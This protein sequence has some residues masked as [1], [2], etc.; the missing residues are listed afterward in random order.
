LFGA[1]GA[2]HTTTDDLKLN[3]DDDE[4][5]ADERHTSGEEGETELLNDFASVHFTGKHNRQLTLYLTHLHLPGLTSVDQMHLLAVADT[6]AHFNADVID[7]MSLANDRIRQEQFGG[8]GASEID[9]TT[10]ARAAVDDCGL[11]FLIA[12]KQHEYLLRCLPI[13]QRAQLKAAGLATHHVI[14]ALH[15]ET[16]MELLASLSQRSSSAASGPCWSE[17]RA[18][19]AGWWLHNLQTLRPCIERVAKAAFQ[20]QQQPMDAAIYYLAM[21]KKNVLTHLFKYDFV[22]SQIQANTHVQNDSRPENGRFL[23][24]RL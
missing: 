1:G 8:T 21:H 12:L 22:R 19:G 24:T 14:W 13:K 7:K 16:T 10:V 23:R 2:A 5:D 20:Q 3:D 17:L 9:A 6:L 11:R 4:E 15:S 18:V